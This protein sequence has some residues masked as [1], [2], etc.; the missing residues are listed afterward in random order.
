MPLLVEMWL[1]H[2]RTSNFVG[3]ISKN[4]AGQEFFGHVGHP[5][6]DLFTV[7]MAKSWTNCLP[8]PVK[9]AQAFGVRA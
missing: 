3:V 5:E 1:A 2:V 4:Y 6:C 8:A 7:L 9:S